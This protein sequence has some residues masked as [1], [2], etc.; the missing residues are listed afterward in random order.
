MCGG[1]A[2]SHA[3]VH[4]TASSMGGGREGALLLAAVL[5]RREVCSRQKQLAD[6]ALQ[7]VMT[8]SAV[9]TSRETQ[10]S[11]LPHRE[12]MCSRYAR[13]VGSTPI[14]VPAIASDLSYKRVDRPCS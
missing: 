7:N 10:G 4:P 11:R 9:R 1:A 6:P 3:G 14:A 12:D 13:A 2:C 5:V 8:S